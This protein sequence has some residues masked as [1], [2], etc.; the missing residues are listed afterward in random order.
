MS[1]DDV[2]C[3][4]AGVVVDSRLPHASAVTE[5]HVAFG[6]LDLWL[7]AGLA[8]R[9]DAEGVTRR[10]SVNGGGSANVVAVT[11]VGRVRRLPFAVELL[12]R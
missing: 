6:K 10:G 9:S 7:D 4:C 5:R 2:L 8:S 3:E 12:M 1:H 11:K